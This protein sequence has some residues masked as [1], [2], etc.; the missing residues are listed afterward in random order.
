MADMLKKGR[1]GETEGKEGRKEIHKQEK[2]E[3][4]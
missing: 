1:R 3:N 4:S 2:S